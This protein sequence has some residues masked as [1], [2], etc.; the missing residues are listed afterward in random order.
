MT[1]LALGKARSNRIA[2]GTHDV[3]SVVSEVTTDR[4]VLGT[5]DV[6]I[7]REVSLLLCCCR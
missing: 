1:S 5:Y 3:T 7:I 6:S 4:I 2:L